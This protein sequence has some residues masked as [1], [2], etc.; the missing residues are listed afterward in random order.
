MQAAPARPDRPDPQFEN[1]LVAS[2]P[3]VRRFAL[4]YCGC[5]ADANDAIQTGCE[6]ALTHWYQ[7]SGQGPFD[8]WL[9]KIMVNAWRGPSR[10]PVGRFTFAPRTARST[11][12]IPIPLF[13]KAEGSSWMRTAYFWEP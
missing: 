5:A 1:L 6:R 10:I 11:S 9:I 3:K 12:S 7:W 2:L 13:A 8:H 4:A